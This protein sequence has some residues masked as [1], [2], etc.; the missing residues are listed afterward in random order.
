MCIRD[1]RTLLLARIERLAADVR[2]EKRWGM[3][4]L[5]LLLIL[6]LILALTRSPTNLA[7]VAPHSGEY[8]SPPS[9]LH[10][11]NSTE[12]SPHPIDNMEYDSGEPLSAMSTPGRSSSFTL[13]PR[14]VASLQRARRRYATPSTLIRARRLRLNGAKYRRLSDTHTPHMMPDPAATEWT[15]KDSD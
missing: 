2:S 11:P 3:A 13:T 12:A 6:L 1:R 14:P 5:S 4:Q 10:A 9:L 15:E 8:K 7:H